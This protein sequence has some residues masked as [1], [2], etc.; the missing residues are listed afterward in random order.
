MPPYTPSTPSSGASASERWR[1]SSCAMFC[2]VFIEGGAWHSLRMC[3]VVPPGAF[4]KDVSRIARRGAA[5]PCTKNV[6]RGPTCT[7]FV[8][9]LLPSIPCVDT[10][11]KL[12][13]NLCYNV[14]PHMW[15]SVGCLDCMMVEGDRLLWRGEQ[16]ENI[17]IDCRNTPKP[18]KHCCC[19]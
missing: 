2:F 6:T 7:P 17:I 15:D 1:G 18:Y 19:C 5:Q 14:L 9:E 10:C 12:A 13:D 8:G 4:S 11:P 16:M 3:C